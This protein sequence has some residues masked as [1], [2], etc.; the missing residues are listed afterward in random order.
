MLQ[1]GGREWAICKG[2]GGHA[3]NELNTRVCGIQIKVA[4]ELISKKTSRTAASG[5]AEESATAEGRMKAQSRRQGAR[6]R[7]AR[8]NRLGCRGGEF[9]TNFQSAQTGMLECGVE[10]SNARIRTARKRS[11]PP[12]KLELE[13]GPGGGLVALEKC[14]GVGVRRG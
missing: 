14:R 11:F 6:G 1:P 3:I 13:L 7:E 5:L 8:W 9:E 2:S 10:L 4:G 12:R